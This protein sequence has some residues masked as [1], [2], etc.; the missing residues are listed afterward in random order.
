MIRPL[1]V[2]ALLLH[3]PVVLVRVAIPVVLWT[4]HRT[5]AWVTLPLAVAIVWVLR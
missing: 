2:L 4:I 3:A 1:A 5:Q